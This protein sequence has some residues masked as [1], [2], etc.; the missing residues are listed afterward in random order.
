MMVI[1]EKKEVV[2]ELN[3]IKS[4]LLLEKYFT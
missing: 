2:I 3:D 4:K 1:V